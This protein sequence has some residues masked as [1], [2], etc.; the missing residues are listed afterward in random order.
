MKTAGPRGVNF[1]SRLEARWAAFFDAV[2][3]PWQYE[4]DLGLDRWIPDFLI[5]SGAG[6]LVEVKPAWTLG[7]LEP[8]KE[9]IEKSGVVAQVLLVGAALA[10]H[11]ISGNAYVGLHGWN[12]GWRKE[13][14]CWEPATFEKVRSLT[15]IETPRT[16]AG[17][18][19]AWVAASNALQWKPK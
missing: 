3:W 4:P 17:A 19:R 15:G 13:H 10:F 7:S 1:R 9:R 18:Q 2:G 5:T 11:D 6:L 8:H 12:G 14:L 16:V